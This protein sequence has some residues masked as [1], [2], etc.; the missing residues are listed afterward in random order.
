VLVGN[1]SGSFDNPGSGRSNFRR[2]PIDDPSTTDRMPV[3]HT[4]H[5]PD[6]RD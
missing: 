2:P 3:D 1:S 6:P 4:R 5:D